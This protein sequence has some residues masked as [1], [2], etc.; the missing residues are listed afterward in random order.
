[1][2]VT[3]CKQCLISFFVGMMVTIMAEKIVNSL[4]VLTQEE[5][6]SFLTMLFGIDASALLFVTCSSIA[7]V[8]TGGINQSGYKLLT[9]EN[10][11]RWG[12]ICQF[13]AVLTFFVLAAIITLDMGD[14]YFELHAWHFL[15]ATV[16]IVIFSISEGNDVQVA[17]AWLRDY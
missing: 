11:E 14:G 2:S 13:M 17:G 12:G 6:V 4:L 5:G 3:K 15:V 16:S 7:A 1:M 10:R 9:S 8:V